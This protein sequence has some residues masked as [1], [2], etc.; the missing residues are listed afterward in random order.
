V[1]A[2]ARQ[3]TILSRLIT[4]LELCENLVQIYQQQQQNPPTVSMERTNQTNAKNLTLCALLGLQVGT[5][6][7]GLLLLCLS[8]SHGLK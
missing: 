4:G 8:L 5:Q 1:L 3:I 2:F 6:L 7:C